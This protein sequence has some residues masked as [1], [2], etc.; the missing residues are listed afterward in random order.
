MSA[1][2]LVTRKV[3]GV[4]LVNDAGLILMQLRD[5]KAPVAPNKWSLVG[6]HLEPGEDPEAGA[7]RE[8]E[9]ETALVAGDLRLDFHET[10]TAA[11]GSAQTEWWVYTGRTSATKADI[12][13]GEGADITFVE[14]ELAL[15]L[16]LAVPAA[17]F[18]PRFLKG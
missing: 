2:P 15:T 1:A 12:V 6:G 5:D 9:E 18:L 10:T 3:A 7:R 14:P 16:D 13:V 17:I 4:I 8:L 11:D